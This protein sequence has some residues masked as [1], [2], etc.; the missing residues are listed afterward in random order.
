MESI[1]ISSGVKRVCING[2]P[3]RVIEF[4]P[5][6]VTFAE[7]FY[8]LYK[9]FGSKQ[10]EY[11]Q[12]A[13]ELDAHKLEVDENGF[14]V[15]A[16]EGIAFLREVCEFM[17]SKIDGLF[18]IGTSQKAFGDALNLNMFNEFFTGITPYVESARSEKLQQYRKQSHKRV[19]K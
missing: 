5:S 13:K 17:R 9:D 7:K 8:Q 6:D 15:N 12:R 14:S 19:M 4:S 2:D 11:E 10:V 1:N 16:D 3:D 18:G